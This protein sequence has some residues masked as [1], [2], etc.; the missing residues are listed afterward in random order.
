VRTQVG[1]VGAG[2]AGLLLSHLLHL[3]G[4]ESVVLEARSRQHV[5]ERVR[6]GILEQDTV[7]LLNDTG[8]GARMMR[9]GLV[10]HGIELQFGHERHR[11]DF[12]ELT[13]GKSVMVYAQHEVLK[14]LIEARIAAKGQLLFDVEDVSVS[15]FDGAAPKIHFRKGG[16]LQELSCDFIAGCAGFHGVCR[17]SVPAGALKIFERTYPFAWLGL[18]AQAPPSSKELIYAYHERGFALLS[19]RSPEISRLYIQ[20]APDEDIANWSDARIWQG[21]S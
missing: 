6:T 8:V 18:L 12:Q 7:D 13:G 4:I 2:P 10:H 5:E 19:M 14:D 21:A 20:C 11:I 9:Q 15:E 17:P 16:S 1:I 3:Q